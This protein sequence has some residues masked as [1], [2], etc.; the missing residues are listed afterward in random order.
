[1]KHKKDKVDKDLL[2][3]SS[4]VRRRPSRSI[5][6]LP[7]TLLGCAGAVLFGAL[8]YANE[9][10]GMDPPESQEDQRVTS[11]R[12][13]A[14][15]LTEGY[16]GGTIRSAAA[17]RATETAQGSAVTPKEDESMGAKGGGVFLVASDDL[18]KPGQAWESNRVDAAPPVA[19]GSENGGQAAAATSSA[20]PP[21]GWHG[22]DVPRLERPGAMG[23]GSMQAAAAVNPT[24][25]LRQE[26]A[27]VRKQ[28]FLRALQADLAVPLKTRGLEQS[29]RGAG[30]GMNAKLAEVDRELARLDQ[31]AA[32]G[33]SYLDKLQALQ[34]SGLLPQQAAE[35]TGATPKRPR[36][37]HNLEQFDG[38]K[39]RWHSDA[40]VEDPQPFQLRAGRRIAIVLK[41]HIN[42]DLPGPIHAEVTRDVLDTVTGEVLIPQG[43]VALGTY[44]ADIAFGQ[45]RLFGVWQRLTF[46]D[47]KVI[48][49]GAMPTSD[50]AGRAGM[51]GNVNTH[52]W[53][54]FG[55]AL[56]MSAIGT[57]TAVSTDQFA[58]ENKVTVGGT[59]AQQLGVQLGQ[60]SE[61]MIR[62]NMEIAPT[63]EVEPGTIL[64]I[65]VQKDLTFPGPYGAFD[66]L[67]ADDERFVA[68]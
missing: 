8:V 35:Q 58:Q 47:D 22:S 20:G 24:D 56:L 29:A 48:D 61:E 36:N 4:P 45:E 38:P 64:A 15:Q 3:E 28:M 32:S 62:R 67:S 2:P 59:M 23:G 60:L 63:I 17:G 65:E 31:D 68:H 30:G 33:D 14:R 55:G 16:G 26:M 5:S 52:F 27:E 57:G 43:T 6:A 66:Y 12:D 46:P 54:V 11:A 41:D 39:D 37:R 25:A 53:R 10:R 50:G 49:L 21:P 44:A 18:D 34:Q 1:M 40:R 9:T 19:P 13:V 7:L 51:G 42:S